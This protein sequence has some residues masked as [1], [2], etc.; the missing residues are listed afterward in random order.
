MSYHHQFTGH[1]EGIHPTAP[2]KWRV[3]DGLASAF[4]EAEGEAGGKG[5]YISANPR[6]SIFFTDVS[7]IRVTNQNDAVR[8][9]GRPM[10]RAFYVPAG[11]SMW[12]SF[13]SP[14]SFSHLDIHLTPEKMVKFLAPSLGRTAALAVARR[15]AEVDEPRDLEMLARLLV[16]EVT[17]PARHDLYAESL[18][19]SLVA[20]MLDLGE[21]RTTRADG[22]LTRAQMRKI[23][24]R[25][26]AGGGRRLTVAEM[27]EAV[28]LSESWFTHVFKNTTGMTP[29]QWQSTRRIDLAKTLLGEGVLS[30]SEIA[31]RLGFSDQAHLTRVFNQVEGET[32]AVWRRAHQ[33]A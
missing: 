33:S 3:F 24:A 15:P 12:T 5:Y 27:A 8:R 18:A 1:T 13:T 17:N 30:I 26:E 21:R 31:D 28:G 20:G 6:V 32:P 4:W 25:F 19:G 2:L 16:D 23:V 29:L 22:R 7:S 10:A 11:T 9:T 14:L